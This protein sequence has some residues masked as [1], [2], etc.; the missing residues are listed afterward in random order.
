M[1]RTIGPI[2]DVELSSYP[3][4]RSKREVEKRRKEVSLHILLQ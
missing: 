2:M 3:F 1:R 4:S